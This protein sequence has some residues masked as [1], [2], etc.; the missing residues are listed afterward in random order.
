M[1]KVI[2]EVFDSRNTCI[3]QDLSR[4][5]IHNTEKSFISN[6]KMTSKKQ[7]VHKVILYIDGLWEEYEN[8]SL[9]SWSYPNGLGQIKIN[10]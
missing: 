7:G 3:P 2:M 8:G 1:E 4:A 9:T 5:I 6:A 10:S